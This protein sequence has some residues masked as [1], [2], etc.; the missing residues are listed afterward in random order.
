MSEDDALQARMVARQ[1][2]D[3][4]TL[5]GPAKQRFA[6]NDNLDLPRGLAHQGRYALRMLDLFDADLERLMATAARCRQAAQQEG[7]ERRAMWMRA[8]DLCELAVARVTNLAGEDPQLQQRVAHRLLYPEP[9]PGEELLYRTVWVAR[10][11]DPHVLFRASCMERLTTGQ[12]WARQVRPLRAPRSCCRYHGGDWH[13]AARLAIHL[14]RRVHQDQA[15]TEETFER[16]Q[17]LADQG[18][19]PVW[20]RKA[21]LSLL[22]PADGIIVGRLAGHDEPFLINGQHRTQALVEAG[23]RRTVALYE[24]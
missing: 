9:D 23:V 7:P 14:L 4:E 24:R 12:R 3:S 19:H 20:V 6:T 22:D 21:A 5:T 8:T 15:S 11:P 16:A 13:Q 17:H 18:G 1:C 10:L 2:W